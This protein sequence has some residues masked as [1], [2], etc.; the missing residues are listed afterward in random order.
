MS[1]IKLSQISFA[2][3]IINKH[4]GAHFHASKRPCLYNAFPWEPSLL[5]LSIG[6]HYWGT[7]RSHPL[8]ILQSCRDFLTYMSIL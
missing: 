7:S 4:F 1:C 5:E 8:K 2:A 6:S 3:L